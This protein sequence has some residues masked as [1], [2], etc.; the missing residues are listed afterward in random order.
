MCDGKVE[1]TFLLPLLLFKNNL[2]LN[3]MLEWRSEDNLPEAAV[4]FQHLRPGHQTW[5]VGLGS[6]LQRSHVA[7][8]I[9]CLFDVGVGDGKG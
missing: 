3:N 6:K 4:S 7:C 8:P 1:Q 5:V 2:F 9:V